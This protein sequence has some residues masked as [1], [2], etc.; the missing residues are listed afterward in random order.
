MRQQN[1]FVWC[2]QYSKLRVIHFVW[3]TPLLR[4]IALLPCFLVL[5]AIAPVASAYIGPG[6]GISVIGSLLG[7]L[8]TL[9]L[10]VGAILLWPLRRM[11]KR[12]R[13]GGELA[14]MDETQTEDKEILEKPTVEIVAV[15]GKNAA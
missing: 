8:L 10:A 1:S 3:E 14:G 7:L 6:S 9:F 4:K 12:R 2:R 15:E 11:L 13:A 5:I